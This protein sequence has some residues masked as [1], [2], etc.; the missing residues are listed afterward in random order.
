MMKIVIK[1]YSN[2]KLYDSEQKKYV[3]LQDIRNQI[4]E[5]N[6]VE[7]IDNSNGKNITNHVLI[8][9][10]LEEGKQGNSTIPSSLLHDMIRMGNNVIENGMNQIK[11][12]IDAV[13]QN[14]INK[15]SKSSEQIEIKKLESK[16][17]DLENLIE[18]II[19][20]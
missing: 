1:R 15:W 19:H 18:K 17:S 14:S 2:R 10:I 11:T 8:Q 4:R 6:E 3:S 20:E 13:I 12:N 7:I 9:I 5:G 16:I